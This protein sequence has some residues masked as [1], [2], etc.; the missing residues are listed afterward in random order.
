MLFLRIIL[1]KR[2]PY[3]VLMRELT[4]APTAAS[5]GRRHGARADG[6]RARGIPG[7]YRWQYMETQLPFYDT[8]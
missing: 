1:S 2:V 8:T 7:G 4:R 3:A 6:G 5:P